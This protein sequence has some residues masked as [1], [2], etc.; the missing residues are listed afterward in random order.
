MTTH[1]DSTLPPQ[2]RAAIARFNDRSATVAVVGLGYVGLPLVRAVHDAGFR[3]VG[4][5]VDAAKIAMLRRGEAYLKHLGEGF[6]RGLA[7]SDRFEATDDPAGLA[8]ADA[9]VLC[10]PT[11]LSPEREPDLSFVERS[12]ALA[13]AGVRAGT[14]VSLES[15]SYP[16]TTREVCL[17]IVE[18]AA[19]ARGLECGRDWFL[20]FSP[21]REDP[22]S[23]TH[24]TRTIPRLVGG[25]DPASTAVGVALYAAALERVIAVESAEVAEAAKLLENVYRAVN[26]AL[27]NELK[28]VLA[29]MGIDVWQ[30][31][32][33]AATKPFGF[34]PFYPGPG[35]GGHCIPIDP[36]YL[37]WK[38]RQVGERTRFIE[39][40]GE[41]NSR[42]PERVVDRVEAV[43]RDEG[44]ALRGADVLVLGLA[45][46]PNVDDVRE[47]P[48]AEII[49]LL[50]ERGARVAYHDPHVP[51]FPRMRRYRF[52]LASEPLTPG[53]LARADCVLVVTHHDAIDWQLVADHARLVVDTRDAMARARPSRARIVKA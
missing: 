52:E 15:T 12:T 8:R 10:V 20:V 44:R 23:A 53:R 42:M 24:S 19:R 7:A 34:Q 31:V 41:I 21:E 16:G 29:A 35:L 49:R 5:D 22:G 4:F 13:A 36:F 48:A 46:K 33:A 50:S 43:L 30:V 26:I 32:R 2:A 51:A 28:P 45:Y 25:V 47:T 11:P 17:P 14:L 40:A 3:V 1:P 37:A 39:L 38:A 6:V 9:I 27:V 18:R